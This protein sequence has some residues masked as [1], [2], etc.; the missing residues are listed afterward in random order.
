MLEQDVYTRLESITA[1]VVRRVARRPSARFARWWY[2]DE[3]RGAF[4]LTFI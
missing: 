3:S 4:T 1:N 2:I